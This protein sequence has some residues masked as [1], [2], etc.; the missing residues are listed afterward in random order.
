MT[1]AHFVDWL[2]DGLA[3]LRLSYNMKALAQERSICE[4]CFTWLRPA[5]CHIMTLVL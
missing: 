5:L 1:E 4:I 2:R 3:Q